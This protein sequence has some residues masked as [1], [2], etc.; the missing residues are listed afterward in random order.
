ML[1]LTDR[2]AAIRLVEAMSYLPELEQFIDMAT[3][4]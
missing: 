4:E 2:N 3:A 1:T